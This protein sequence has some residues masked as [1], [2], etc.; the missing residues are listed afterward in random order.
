MTLT[1]LTDTLLDHGGG[2]LWGWHVFG[3]RNL[4]SDGKDYAV[5]AAAK[6]IKFLLHRYRRVVA[7]TD[8]GAERVTLLIGRREIVKL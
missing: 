3:N 8:H 6:R 5:H 2:G 1:T 7:Y 4:G